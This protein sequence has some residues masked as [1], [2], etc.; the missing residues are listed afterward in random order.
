M[1]PTYTIALE[2]FPLTPNGKTD[3]KAL[4]DPQTVQQG[5]EAQA[6]QPTN[7]LER[8]LLQLWQQHLGTDAIGVTD[9]FFEVGGHSLKAMTL[10]RQAAEQLQQPVTLRN[11]FNAPTVRALATLLSSGKINHSRL[12]SFGKHQQGQPTLLLLPP[13]MGSATVFSHL[14]VALASEYNC[15]GY[16]YPGFEASEQPVESIETLAA[17]VVQEAKQLPSE[18]LVLTG[19]SM[20]AVVAY[21]VA[22][23]LA[24][25]GFEAQLVLIDRP[26]EANTGNRRKLGA[27]TLA[28]LAQAELADWQQAS[29]MEA[30]THLNTLVAGHLNALQHYHLEEQV[31]GQIVAIAGNDRAATSMDGWAR[32]TEGHFS[33]T[34]IDASHYQLVAEAPSVQIAAA[35][36]QAT[37]VSK[38]N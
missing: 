34:A 36:Q 20:G 9:N 25:Q 18:G 17:Q 29:G 5:R 24:S 8:T 21:E 37:L 38:S 13:V 4:P 22:R 32:F 2:A 1:V 14:A 31:P 30:A 7:D 28:K 6:E 11:L 23:Q 3:R 15:Y 35:I 33:S 12:I 26:A 16:T 19:Y 10:V 27:K